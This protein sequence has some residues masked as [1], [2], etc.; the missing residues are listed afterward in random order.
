MKPIL[1][2]L[3]IFIMGCIGVNAQVSIEKSA[4]IVNKSLISFLS[5]ESKFVVLS[6][7]LIPYDST[8][9]YLNDSLIVVPIL[10]TLSK[11]SK[12]LGNDHMGKYDSSLI[13]MATV[14]NAQNKYLSNRGQIYTKLFKGNEVNFR[15]SAKYGDIELFIHVPFLYDGN[16]YC[17]ISGVFK[18]EPNHKFAIMYLLDKKLNIIDRGYL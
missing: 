14:L 1:S 2:F 7:D 16:Y 5:R 6:R 11:S 4:R 18:N 17:L 15:Q 12:W 3:F 13:F 8:D 9:Y 10:K